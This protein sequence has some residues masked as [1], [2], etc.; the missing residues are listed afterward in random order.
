MIV[1]NVTFF[2]MTDPLISAVRRVVL[3]LSFRLP[4]YL[5][6][7]PT[8]PPGGHSDNSSE[9]RPETDA[10]SSKPGPGGE[11]ER[12]RARQQ[13]L[14]RAKFRGA[15]G[16]AR[17]GSSPDPGRAVRPR[18]P[19]G[20]QNRRKHGLTPVHHESPRADFLPSR[21]RALTN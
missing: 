4:R 8:N 13:P 21:A 10:K 1:E 2:T 3:R 9:H 11:A 19:L 16:M 14:S 5:N 18:A 17:A 20:G 15:T 6:R 12:A 7:R